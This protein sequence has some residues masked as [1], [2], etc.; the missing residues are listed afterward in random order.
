MKKSF[1]VLLVLIILVLAA[2]TF[3]LAITGMTNT[4]RADECVPKDA[5][6]ETIEHPAVTHEEEIFDHW[7]RY[8]YNGPW[9]SNTEAPPFPS[10]K[11]Q[12]NT[13]SDPHGI[14]VPGA[15][16][17]S[18]GNSGRGDWFYLEAVTV[19]I[20]V[21][22][23][24]AWTETIEHPAVTCEDPD[25]LGCGDDGYIPVGDECETE[26]PPV[27]KGR[28]VVGGPCAPS[29]DPEQ[30]PAVVETE[31]KQNYC[32]KKNASGDVVDVVSYEPDVIE[33]GL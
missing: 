28:P 31:C 9:E 16:F 18:N 17:R 10:D 6:T 19:V 15:Y 7:Q 23:E 25:P 24:E 1:R 11:W 27:C 8:S 29:T 5:W 26:E 3:V 4:A 22:D 14:G 30:P 2:V 20:V 13:Q 32:V 33:E 12:A 21:T